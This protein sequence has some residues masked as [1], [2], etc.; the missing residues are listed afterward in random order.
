MGLK[1][2][3]AII[4]YLVHKRPVIF[5]GNAFKCYFCRSDCCSSSVNPLALTTSSFNQNDTFSFF[6]DL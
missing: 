5:T 2:M 3:N 6:R 4:Q 1:D